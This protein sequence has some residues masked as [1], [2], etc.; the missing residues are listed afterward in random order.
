[1]SEKGTC[2][3]NTRN[4][5]LLCVPS[6]KHLQPA[7]HQYKGFVKSVNTKCC[8]FRPA[9]HNDWSLNCGEISA[10]HKIQGSARY[11]RVQITL[12]IMIQ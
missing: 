10:T 8:V 9:N 12:I 6:V 1:M 4:N 11:C 5:R 2:C 3:H 7:C